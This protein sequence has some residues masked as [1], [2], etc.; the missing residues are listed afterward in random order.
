MVPLH[1][2]TTLLWMLTSPQGRN[3]T[4]ACAV[5]R[6]S[7]RYGTVFL[8]HSFLLA[9]VRT[10]CLYVVCFKFGSSNQLTFAPRKTNGSDGTHNTVNKERG[11]LFKPLVYQA[12]EEGEETIALCRCGKSETRPVCDYSHQ[13]LEEGDLDEQTQQTRT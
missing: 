8:F 1:T 13:S 9:S 11:T 12:S 4:F 3:A 7:F 2:L 10:Y 6:T 5:S